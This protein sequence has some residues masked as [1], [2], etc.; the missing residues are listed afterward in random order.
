MKKLFSAIRYNS[1]SEFRAIPKPTVRLRSVDECC[2]EERRSSSPRACL[3]F[4]ALSVW[5]WIGEKLAGIVKW[6]TA[7]HGRRSPHAETAAARSSLFEKKNELG[8]GNL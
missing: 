7:V 5:Y 3:A 6:I 2:V 4:A 1:S 8:R